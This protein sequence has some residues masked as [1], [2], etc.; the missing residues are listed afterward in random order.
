MQNFKIVSVDLDGTLLNRDMTLSEENKKAMAELTS[1]GILVVPNTGRT[2][3]EMPPE[4]RDDEHVRYI[5]HSDGAA[6]YDKATGERYSLGMPRDTA[7]RVMKILRSYRTSLS[8]RNN[9]FSYVKAEEHNKESY[10][11]YRI[12]ELYQMF[13]FLTNQPVENFDSFVD[14]LDEVEMV[15]SFF[16]DENELEECR[17][18]LLLMGE[19]QIASSA[20]HNIEVFSVRA[21]K[22]NALLH[23]AERL[24]IDKDATI[25]VGDSTNDSDMVK[26]A[27][28]G[29]AMENAC[30]ELKSI[31]D[32]I[33]CRNSEHV[34]KYLLEKY[35]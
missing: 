19:V 28:L 17:E 7:A 10:T 6:I 1:R 14:S 32:A 18:K 23:L 35:F 30:D 20:P 31:A 33:A 4:V 29:L 3:S 12:H 9:G 25:A 22:G 13:L 16:A 2:L 24:G 8:V 34:M 26:K 11:K 21:G 15:C 27:G 5:I